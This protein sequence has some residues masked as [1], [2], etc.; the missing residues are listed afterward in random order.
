VQFAAEYGEEVG[1]QAPSGFRFQVSGFSAAAP[2]HTDSLT[3]LADKNVRHTSKA[4]GA[5]GR[6]ARLSAPGS[7]SSIGRW[8]NSQ[9]PIH[10]LA[11]SPASSLCKCEA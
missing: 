5:L 10:R 1:F 6:S 2:R 11:R 3:N 4:T 7:L 8:S 9:T